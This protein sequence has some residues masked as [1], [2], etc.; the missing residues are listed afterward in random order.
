[1]QTVLDGGR[2]IV[3]HTVTLM[4]PTIDSVIVIVSNVPTMLLVAVFNHLYVRVAGLLSA[5]IFSLSC[6]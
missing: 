1:M 4:G 3:L 2:G 6:G 5:T